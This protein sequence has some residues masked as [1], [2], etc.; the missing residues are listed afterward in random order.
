MPFDRSAVVVAS[1]G[2]SM[3]GAWPFGSPAGHPAYRQVLHI[4]L[5]QAISLSTCS[6]RTYVAG[7]LPAL[8]GGVGQGQL[9]L[10]RPRAR[11]L[12]IAPVLDDRYPLEVGGAVEREFYSRR[13][14]SLEFLSH[15]VAATAHIR[16]NVVGRPADPAIPDPFEHG[17]AGR[18][19]HP[20]VTPDIF[21]WRWS[22]EA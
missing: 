19:G 4:G 1:R 3:W 16:K 5:T 2:V 9:G 12:D 14:A 7:C 17:F 20:H 18:L 22:L 10:L 15:K 11:R 13:L 21:V 8:R 6:P